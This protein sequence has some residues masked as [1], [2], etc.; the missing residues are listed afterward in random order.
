MPAGENAPILYAGV[1]RW[2]GPVPAS[3][4]IRGQACGPVQPARPGTLE[5][6]LAER[7]LLYTRGGTGS[8]RGKSI[9]PHTRFSRPEVLSLDENLLA[10]AGIVRPPEHPLAH[11]AAGVNVEV[12]S[13]RRSR[14]A[15]PPDTPDGTGQ[16]MRAIE[17]SQ[18]TRRPLS[19]CTPS[20]ARETRP[21]RPFLLPGCHARSTYPLCLERRPGQGRPTLHSSA[22]WP[23]F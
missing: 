21:G 2:P 12:F 11:F 5:H 17:A 16:Q 14:Q 19:Q 8:I 20:Q 9:T 22:T 10:A 7:Y 4:L 23:V 6:F 3:Y 1:R 18:S 13:L 15:R